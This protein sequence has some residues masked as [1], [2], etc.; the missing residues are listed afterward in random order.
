MIK[1]I[2]TATLILATF[3]VRAD[4]GVLRIYTIQSEPFG[5]L[6]TSTQSGIMYD[7]ANMI[8]RDAHI[9]FKN[10]IVP[11]ARSSGGLIAGEADIT[12][13]YTNDE[14]V[15]GAEQIATLTSLPTIVIGKVGTSYSS[16][17]DLHGKIVAVMRSGKFD[18]DFDADQQITKEIVN[19]YAQGLKMLMGNR[20]DGIIGS[21]VGIYYNAIKL[22]YSKSDFGKP[23][24]LN[25]RSFVLHYSKR[26]N[27]KWIK[28]L[29]Q[30]AEKL[31]NS[32][33]IDRVFK[34]YLGTTAD[35]ILIK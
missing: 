23:V 9:P 22:G 18:D 12:L 30:S 31:N 11:Y 28:P 1:F 24:V 16:L 33:A 27:P 17:N 29:Q 3:L 7:V 6:G 21:N 34:Q 10:T 25:R 2:V 15:R 19:D 26:T 32:G 8:A 5:I 35:N 14:L 4:D 13:R 20:V